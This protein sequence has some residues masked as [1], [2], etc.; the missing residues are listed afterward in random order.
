VLER[1]L[2]GTAVMHRGIDAADMHRGTAVMHR[3][4]LICTGALTQLLCTGAQLLCT[5]AQLLCTG[6]Q[7]ICTGALAR[8]KGKLCGRGKMTGRKA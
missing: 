6:T 5:G 4:K 3:D 1:H 8:M 7:L 2:R